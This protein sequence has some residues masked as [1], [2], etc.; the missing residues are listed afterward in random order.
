MIRCLTD[1]ED[2]ATYLLLAAIFITIK[3]KPVIAAAAVKTLAHCVQLFAEIV[4]G[5]ATVRLG[6][7]QFSSKS[8]AFTS[9][10]YCP[11]PNSEDGR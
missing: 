6:S 4:D 9:G 5:V 11:A 10:C 1:D 8:L 7:K 3:Q 2:G